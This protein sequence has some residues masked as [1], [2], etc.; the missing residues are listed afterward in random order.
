MEILEVHGFQ[1]KIEIP[2]KDL[3]EI[4]PEYTGLWYSSMNKFKVGFNT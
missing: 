2:V 1:N 3:Y 4:K